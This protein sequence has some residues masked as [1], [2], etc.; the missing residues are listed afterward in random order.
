MIRLREAHMWVQSVIAI[1]QV[2]SPR[3]WENAS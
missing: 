1:E 2:V 3:E